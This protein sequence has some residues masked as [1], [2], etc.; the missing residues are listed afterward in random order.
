[1]IGPHRSCLGTYSSLIP[2]AIYQTGSLYIIT[3]SKLK[4]Y[5]YLYPSGFRFTIPN[6]CGGP[7]NLKLQSHVLAHGVAPVEQQD[8]KDEV[9]QCV[10]PIHPSQFNQQPIF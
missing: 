1:M 10:E 4:H 8:A 3:D 6:K 7:T 9:L 5:I 2:I